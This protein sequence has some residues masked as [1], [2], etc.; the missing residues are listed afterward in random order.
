MSCN[1]KNE[2]ELWRRQGEFGSWERVFQE[3]GKAMAR[4]CIAFGGARGQRAG[5]QSRR[6]GTCEVSRQG[7]KELKYAVLSATVRILML[8]L[9]QWTVTQV[10]KQ[11]SDIVILS[12]SK[13]PLW[14]YCVTVYK[15][16]Q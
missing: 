6:G 5:D 12:I 2:S 1:L 16:G 15:D 4:D 9:K 14:L 10:L 8:I 7:R 3:R 11:E 13:R